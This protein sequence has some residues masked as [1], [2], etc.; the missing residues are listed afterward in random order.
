MVGDAWRDD[1]A[2]ARPAGH[3]MRFDQTG[4]DT[5]IRLDE[6][7]V[8]LDRRST[9][10]GDAEIDMIGV[11]ARIMVLNSNP[12]HDPRVAYQFS[13]LFA[14]VRSMQA[15]SNQNNDAIERYT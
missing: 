1:L 14:D 13:K 6:A 8:E 3:E 9:R 15:S 4:G 5:Q 2:A 11:V 12:L 10:R 7:A